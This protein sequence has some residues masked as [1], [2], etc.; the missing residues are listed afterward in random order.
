MV[1]EVIAIAGFGYIAWKLR[2]IEQK[3]EKIDANRPIWQKR[4]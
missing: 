2:N 1:I 4:P 3:L